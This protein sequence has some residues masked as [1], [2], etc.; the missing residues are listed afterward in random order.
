LIAVVVQGG[1]YGSEVAAPVVAK[2]FGYIVAH[3][4][5]QTH[6]AAPSSTKSTSSVCHTSTTTTTATGS[7]STTTTTVPCTSAGRI[8]GG[9]SQTSSRAR[10]GGTRSRATADPPADRPRTVAARSP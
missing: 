3:P 5:T 4:E 8:A 7:G 6:L 1:G 9:L 2:G 10:T